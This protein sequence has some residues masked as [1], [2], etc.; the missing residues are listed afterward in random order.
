MSASKNQ[1]QGPHVTLAG[2]AGSVPGGMAVPST[3]QLPTKWPI[4]GRHFANIISFSQAVINE[5]S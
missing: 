1:G 2:T 3:Y 4:S 5:I